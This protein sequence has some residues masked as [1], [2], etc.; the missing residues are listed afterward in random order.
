MRV[1]LRPDA[2]ATS[3]RGGY[4]R[5]RWR[6]GALGAR[7]REGERAAAPGFALHPE[8]AAVELDEASRDGEAQARALLQMGRPDL[9]ELLEDAG[10][11]RRCDA[12]AIV[13]HADH[14]VLAGGM[15]YADMTTLGR[16]LQRVGEQVEEHLLDHPLVRVDDADAR[17]DL[18]P[19]A[20]ALTGRAL[21]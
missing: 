8:A 16:E 10:L 11:I 12:D 18:E 19:Q 4:S 5:S 2:A 21:A 3:A 20:D 14:H 1:A 7:Q 13:A 15:R 6:R 9:L 17:V